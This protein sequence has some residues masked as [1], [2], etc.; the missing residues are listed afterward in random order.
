M[1]RKLFPEALLVMDYGTFE[2]QFD[3]HRLERLKSMVQLGTPVSTDSFDDPAV[4]GRL[5]GIEILI[6][7]WGVPLL[8]EARL[9][10]LPKLRAVF[11]CAGSVR[12]LVSDALWDRGIVVSNGAEANAV[13]V[14]E[15]TLATIIL[16]GKRAQ[17]L[18][19][20]AR[21]HRGSNSYG[22]LRGELG[23]L[24]RTVGVVGYSKIG[25]RV[26]ELLQILQDVRV[27]VA[28]PY[29]DPVEVSAAGAT[30]IP[31]DA[32]IPAVDI[33]SLHA[34]ELPSTRHMIGALELAALADNATLINTAR[35]SLV[36]T[37]ALE[38]ACCGGRIT[39]I[40]DVTDPEP[41]DAD[42]ILYDLPNVVLTPHIAGS[43]GTETRRMS[44]M[45]LND[46][47]HYLNDEPLDAQVHAHD[48]N[49]SA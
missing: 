13:P 39:A 29:A 44:D 37:A 9:A 43:L 30:L 1:N 38:E 22:Q 24:G 12:P 5:A 36:D 8:D 4:A 15:F 27:F 35:G 6:T 11:H 45:A 17:V 33:L 21:N 32:L 28:D 14:A 16:A 20:D 2:S 31:L 42:S 26:V 18:A 47:A 41:L 3:S 49:L 23:N 25:R 40:L 7:S 10:Q 46:L 19:N 48:M 34:P